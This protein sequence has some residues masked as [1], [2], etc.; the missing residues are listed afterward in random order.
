MYSGKH[1]LA[2]SAAST[3]ALGFLHTTNTVLISALG[4]TMAIAA[5]HYLPLGAL[6]KLVGR[7]S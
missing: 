6:R 3:G 5:Y 1:L 7:N 4:V 2:T